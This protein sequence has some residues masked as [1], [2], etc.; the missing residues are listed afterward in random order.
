MHVDKIAIIKVIR[1]YLTDNP[2]TPE[3]ITNAQPQHAPLVVG[4]LKLAKNLV[5]RVLDYL[6]QQEPKLTLQIALQV[7]D[8]LQAIL[9]DADDDTSFIVAEYR[10][11]VRAVA[12]VTHDEQLAILLDQCEN[13]AI[14]RRYLMRGIRAYDAK[15]HP[16]PKVTDEEPVDMDCDGRV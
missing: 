10:G 5:F 1:Q 4:N 13:T 15:N 12:D 6:E 9:D 2:A 11:Y 7:R 16:E 14:T 8:K 3:Q